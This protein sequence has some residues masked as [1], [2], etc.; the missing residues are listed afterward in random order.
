M[1]AEKNVHQKLISH[2]I[3]HWEERFKHF[4]GQ[5]FVIIIIFL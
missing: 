1:H 4:A 3:P 5:E 2:K